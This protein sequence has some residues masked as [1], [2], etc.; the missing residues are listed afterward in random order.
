MRTCFFAVQNVIRLKKKRKYRYTF[1]ESYLPIMNIND[2]M[3]SI[4]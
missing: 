2:P 3:S 1:R 4:L